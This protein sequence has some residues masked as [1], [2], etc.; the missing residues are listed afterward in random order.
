MAT[1]SVLSNITTKLKSFFTGTLKV[2]EEVTGI[3]QKAE[4]FVDL[5]LSIAGLAPVATLFNNVTTAAGQ[6]ELAAAAAGQQNGTGAQKAALVLQSVY[7]S[8]EAA[9]QAERMGS[10][11]SGD[12]E[13][14]R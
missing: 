3:A 13:Q 2:A 14:V 8:F 7:A 11:G 4:P 10:P 1:V 5:G 12:R 6:A 9:A